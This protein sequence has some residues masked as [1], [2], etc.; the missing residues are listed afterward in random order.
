LAQ[1]EGFAVS[2]L[3]ESQTEEGGSYLEVARGVL[4]EP[5][6]A[7]SSCFGGFVVVP[8]GGAALVASPAWCG[9]SE[10]DVVE[11]GDDDIVVSLVTADA[12]SD[13][14]VA[15]VGRL[16]GKASPKNLSVFVAACVEAMPRLNSPDH[17]A[18]LDA[19]N[20]GFE[21]HNKHMPQARFFCCSDRAAEDLEEA[22]GDDDDGPR[23]RA[24]AEAP[25]AAERDV[26]WRL[27][28]KKAKAWVDKRKATMGIRSLTL[29]DG[30]VNLGGQTTSN[31]ADIVKLGLVD[32]GLRSRPGSLLEAV[33]VLIKQHNKRRVTAIKAGHTTGIAQTEAL[34]LID[35]TE[36]TKRLKERSGM[37][38][39][40]GA[41]PS[42]VASTAAERPQPRGEGEAYDEDDAGTPLPAA[43][44]PTVGGDGSPAGE[45]P[46]W[47]PAD[48]TARR[49]AAERLIC[50][51]EQLRGR[52][53]AFVSVMIADDVASA[54]TADAYREATITYKAGKFL[55]KCG[56]VEDLITHASGG[57]DERAR[58]GIYLPFDASP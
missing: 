1:A 17:A 23:Y 7:I 33:N 56:D 4:E 31:R 3:R 21:A 29:V 19:K 40:A 12:N 10:M 51:L 26:Q 37:C 18:I 49:S 57:A 32:V 8:P 30:P 27:L 47:F 41:A 38:R 15:A 2:F 20:G 53:V 43:D 44:G 34:D 35:D 9:R 25:N 58:L 11:T 36:I 55:V 16:V 6:E 22:C 45:L 54:T 14:V 13:V 46:P 48:D 42:G 50:R 28:S 39:S 52:H 5:A 24:W